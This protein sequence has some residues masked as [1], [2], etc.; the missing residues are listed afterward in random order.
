MSVPVPV[1]HVI[2]R[3]CAAEA[4]DWEQWRGY[5]IADDAAVEADTLSGA[6]ERMSELLRRRVEPWP[7]EAVVEHVERPL[8]PGLWIREALDEHSDERDHASRVVLEA[9][10]DR[11]ARDQLAALPETSPGGVVVV[12]GVPGDTLAWCLDQHDER[13]ALVVAAAVSN[14]RLWWNALVPAVRSA[15]TGL[16]VASELSD[17]SL[18]GAA[19]LDDWIAASECGRLVTL[20]AAGTASGGRPALLPAAA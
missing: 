20:P 1:L 12:A 19:T 2:Y 3:W 4:G 8:G 10:G 13:G 17:P 9:F 14:H 5:A 7:W 11:R 18:G 16:P 6:R 15:A